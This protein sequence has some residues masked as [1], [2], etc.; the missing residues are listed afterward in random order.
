MWDTCNK[1][2]EKFLNYR[3]TNRQISDTHKHTNTRVTFAV[4]NGYFVCEHIKSMIN[5]RES[6]NSVQM[7]VKLNKLTFS[8]T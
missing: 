1:F 7:K 8:Y 3:Q 5:L 2:C 4:R 6:V